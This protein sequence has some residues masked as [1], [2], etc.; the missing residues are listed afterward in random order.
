MGHRQRIGLMF[1]AALIAFAPT[2]HA[3]DLR[4]AQ[5]HAAASRLSLVLELR[6]LL[7]DRF[8]QT[9]QQNRSVFLQI[10]A[11]LWEDRRIAD[12][13][14]LTTPE[15]IY[16][17]DRDT[18]GGLSVRDQY[19]NQSSHNDFAIVP[20]RIDLGAL[21]RVADD[22]SYYTHAEVTAATVPEQGIDQLGTALFGD[23][24]STAGLASLGRFLFQTVL[25]IG[26][27]LESTSSE[28][29]SPRYTGLQIRAG[30]R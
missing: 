12:R 23:D 27:Y 1:A 26:R 5:L 17:I 14:V 3:F 8:L 15:V 18:A 29:T 25:R 6:D 4:I 7:R 28:I 16:R 11:E 9:I 19:G 10:R 20:I 30:V 21:D 13:L 2:A 24:Q 22:R